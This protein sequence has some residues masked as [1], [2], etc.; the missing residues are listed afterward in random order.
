MA[1]FE[2]LPSGKWRAQVLH[3][4]GRKINIPADRLKSVVRQRAMEVE[5]AIRRGDFVDPRAGRITVSEWYVKWRAAHTVEVA[6]GKRTQSVWHVHVEPKWGSWPLSAIT[7]ME[8]KTWIA[9]LGRTPR[10]R[11]PAGAKEP[12]MLGPATIGDA[13]QILSQ[14]LDEAV[15]EQL[16]AA[17]PMRLVKLPGRGKHEDR[18]I[19]PGEEERL[20]SACDALFI[21]TGHEVWPEFRTFLQVLFGTGMRFQ[22]AAGLQRS[23]CAIFRKRVTVGQVLPRDTR[24][25]RR[26][27]KTEA[28]T[29]RPI[30][31]TDDLAATLAVHLGRHDEDLVFVSADARQ[32][33]HY[34]NVR[35]RHWVKAL[36]RANLS[37]LQPTM[38]DIRHTYGTRLAEAGV[39]P[40]EIGA[41]MGHA[42]LASTERYLHAGEARMD[43]ARE[44]LSP[45]AP[46][47]ARKKRPKGQASGA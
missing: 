24:E 32:P 10:Q 6:T 4:S 15:R 2:K 25:P 41:L 22:E 17:N 1:Y 21:E 37:G 30:P 7:Y 13:G 19:E 38:H 8:C 44:A 46:H 42:R 27:A 33:L 29:G 26:D 9:D 40:H 3:P 36:E 31:I 14:L 28:G 43:R 35:R 34:N 20:Y 39:P 5:T 23:D 45:P 12:V 18:V 47:A 16:I 11:Q